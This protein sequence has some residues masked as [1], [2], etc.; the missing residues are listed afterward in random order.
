MTIRIGVPT[1]VD[2]VLVEATTRERLGWVARDLGITAELPFEL[3]AIDAPAPTIEIAGSTMRWSRATCCRARMFVEQRLMSHAEMNQAFTEPPAPVAAAWIASLVEAVIVNRPEC[4]V[5]LVTSEVMREIEMDASLATW[6]LTALFENG[7]CIAAL[8][9]EAVRGVATGTTARW[10]ERVI[11][12]QHPRSIKIELSL[13]TLRQLLAEDPRADARPF[14]PLAAKLQRELG[15]F[16]P[17][18]Q[19]KPSEDV[20]ARCFRIRINDLAELSQPLVPPKH[21]LYTNGTTYVP[22]WNTPMS[23]APEGSGPSMSALDHLAFE[24]FDT[25]KRRAARL[26]EASDVDRWVDTLGKPALAANARASRYYGDLPQVLRRLLAER[27]SISDLPRILD[28]LVDYHEMR[29]PPPRTHVVLTRGFPV[30]DDR[31]PPETRLLEGV[32]FALGGAI[33]TSLATTSELSVLVLA[34]STERLL[35][36]DSSPHV[37]ERLLAAIEQKLAVAPVDA[38]LTT[39]EIRAHVRKLTA[40]AFP[41]LPVLSF[42][43]LPPTASLYEEGRIDIGPKPTTR[44]ARARV[45]VTSDVDGVAPLLAT[46]KKRAAIASLLAGTTL[47][48]EPDE[49]LR[50][51][52]GLA[53]DSAA[54]PEQI[55]KQGWGVVVPEGPR[56][57]QLLKSIDPLKRFRTQVQGS[58]E[59]IY[60]VPH[61]LGLDA[62]AWVRD[63]FESKA[64][65]KRPRYLLVLGNPREVSLDLQRALAPLAGVGRL[66]FTDDT[67]YGSYAEKAIAAETPTRDELR[68]SVYLGDD[69]SPATTSAESQLILPCMRAL[70]ELVEERQTRLTKHQHVRGDKT[71]LVKCAN[72]ADLLFTV[73]HGLGDKMKYD[74]RTKMQGALLAG[75]ELFSGDDV[76]KG[77]F[78]RGG[79]WMMIACYGLGTPQFS[80]YRSWIAQT[81]ERKGLADLDLETITAGEL[82]DDESPFIADLPRKALANPDG[83]LAIIGHMDLAWSYSYMQDGQPRFDRLFESLRSLL[84]EL[85]VGFALEKL[86]QQCVYASD[87]LASL[88]EH[89]RDRE[90]GKAK[91]VLEP[92]RIPRA[93]MLRQDLRGYMLLGD[94]A[95]RLRT[96][97]G[98]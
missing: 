1:P 89:E 73:S 80:T 84:R 72:Q 6:V 12:Q 74:E 18:V 59:Y 83:P 93:W 4:L 92:Q 47:P 91:E 38:L 69:G 82:A 67:H 24:L 90:R 44:V 53:T 86:M 27:V 97:K 14:A 87:Q 49:I 56:G 2:R 31:P 58:R 52:R 98:T 57:D 77:E 88:Y 68:A 28:R 19:L 7:V 35:L 9:H 30:N 66:D 96:G 32:R 95:T 45:T 33:L 79:M 48:Q 51:S 21:A 46:K 16:V 50:R 15:L 39:V 25:I 76:E 60:R 78:L 42:Q 41:D 5:P 26:V 3:H 55:G 64:E 70:G 22:T 11:S 71:D 13:A 65:D 29:T 85:P 75:E 8:D 81:H 37:T 62:H 63:N 40:E 34:P 61:A 94:P 10:R 36:D 23:V 43:E 17:D 20:A 54:T